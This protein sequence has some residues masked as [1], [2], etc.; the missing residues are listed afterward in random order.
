MQLIWPHA[1]T[2]SGK[3]PSMF[4]EPDDAALHGECRSCL[5]GRDF[6]VSPVVEPGLTQ[7][8]IYFP[9]TGAWFDFYSDARHA[10][11]STE[12]VAVVLEHIPVFVRAGAFIP[13]APPMQSTCAYTGERLDLHYYHDPSVSC[14]AGKMYHDDGETPDAYARGATNCCISPAASHAT[15]RHCPS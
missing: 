5:R 1:R 10:G 15:S 12:T 3:P 11:G 9:R 14:A 8:E 7:K 2:R 4:E 13:L 6:L